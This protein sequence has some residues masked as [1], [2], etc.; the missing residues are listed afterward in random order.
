MGFDDYGN[1]ILQ[2]CIMNNGSGVHFLVA[3]EKMVGLPMMILQ[4]VSRE[5]CGPLIPKP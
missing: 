1:Y 4:G 3:Y 2:E 5:T